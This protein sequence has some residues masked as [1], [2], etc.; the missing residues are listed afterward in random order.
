M[1]KGKKR[2]KIRNYTARRQ[3]KKLLEFDKGMY[4]DSGN[5]YPRL[6]GG[7]K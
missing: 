3:Y 5:G 6:K 1:A 2:P 4:G 7:L